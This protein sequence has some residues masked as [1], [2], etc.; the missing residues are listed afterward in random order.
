MKKPKLNS[1]RGETSRQIHC[2]EMSSIQKRNRTQWV[3]HFWWKAGLTERPPL[4][5]FLNMFISEKPDAR[6]KYIF[7]RFAFFWG[8]QGKRLPTVP[9][10]NVACILWD[11]V[12]S[13]LGFAS[14]RDCPV[15]SQRI[16]IESYCHQFLR[17]SF[18]EINSLKLYTCDPGI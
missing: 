11:L 16:R 17:N 13:S 7:W 15:W 9:D 18:I 6:P 10:W 5:F 8:K 2:I 12:N 1:R 3:H 4:Y 14:D